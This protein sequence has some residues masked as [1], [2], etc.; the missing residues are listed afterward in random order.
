[1]KNFVSPHVHVQSLDSGS[2]PEDFVDR[3]LELGTGC[4]T[5]TDHGT[6]QACRKVYDLAKEKGLKPICGLECYYRDD[7]ADPV[8]P[9]F[10]IPKN[11]KG[12][13]ADWVKYTHLT[14]HFMD[15]AAYETG[16]RL[17]SKADER[18]ERHG[19][20][21]KPI[22]NWAA[23][24]ELGAQNVTIGSG[25]LIGIVGRHVL[26]QGN[27]AVARAYYER[28]RSLVKPGRFI[29]ELMPHDCS[30]YHT[31]GVFITLADG[32]KLKFHDKKVVKTNVGELRAKEL[33]HAFGLKSNEH[34]TL[35]GVKN[36]STWDD[37]PAREIVKVEAI[38]GFV[39]NECST[40]VPDG[41]IQKTI[42]RL[43]LAFARTYGDPICCSDDAHV[44]TSDAQVVQSVR[45]AQ[46]GWGPFYGDYSRY[47]SEKAFEFFKATLGTT[48]KEFEGWVDNSYAWADN[49]KDFTFKNEISLPT[50]FY[51]PKYCEHAWHSNPEVPVKDHSLMYTMELIKKHGRMDW[52]NPKYVERLRTELHLLHNNGTIDLLPYFFLCEEACEVYEKAGELVG[53]GRGSAA[54]LL[55]MYLLDVTHIDPLE[56]NLS[57]D[58]FLTLDRIKSGKLPDVDLDFPHRDLLTDPETGWLHTRFGDH[59]AQISVDSTLKLKMAV[60]DV[61]R[62]K[63]GFVPADVEELAKRFVLPPQGV[64]DYKFVLGYETDEEGHVPGSIEY[65]PSLIEYV[66]KYPE[67]WDVVQKCLGLSRQ[68]GRHACLPAGEGIMVK[69]KIR[70]PVPI[71]KCGGKKVYTGQPREKRGYMPHGVATLLE[72]GKREVWEFTLSTGQFLR[73]TPDHKVLT[74]SGWMEAQEAFQT[75][76]D[77]VKAHTRVKWT[78]NDAENYVKAKN[79][80]LIKWGGSASSPSTYMCEKGHEWI[81]NFTRMISYEHWCKKC[82]YKT[83]FEPSRRFIDPVRQAKKQLGTYIDRD[84]KQGRITSITVETI[85]EARKTGCIYCGRLSTGLERV[86]NGK[87]HTIENCVPA[88]LRC[89]WMRGRYISHAVMIEVGKILKEIDP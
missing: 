29:V 30:K 1:M 3:E 60:R 82:S 54:G 45:L 83:R 75:G 43:M 63:R 12:T 88:C 65:D 9:T 16:V 13:Y 69:N 7:D 14:M 19:A 10:G 67:D 71:E 81:S 61:S 21:R 68:Q 53:P 17:L 27:V 89:N 39:E 22:F 48:E 2:T 66:K 25:C 8:L 4:I 58:R 31:K 79:G 84:K 64:E 85:V 77:L 52:N 35:I 72:Q 55:L 18:A 33:A 62:F 73:C 23:L 38:E 56:Y 49:F 86:D 26:D 11:D 80:K 42:N 74:T 41:D 15:Q 87:G 32:T 51:E 34:T 20:E 6:L 47:S 24:E 44:S 76:T 28:V 59:F 46:K 40:L 70:V 37:S 5:V 50:K 36:Y 57:L 78:E